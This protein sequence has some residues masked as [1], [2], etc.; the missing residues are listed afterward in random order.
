[1]RGVFTGSSH[2]AAARTMEAGGPAWSGFVDDQLAICAGVII[3]WQGL[4]EAW[5]AFTPVG[6]QH[7]LFCHR[8]VTR[9]LK[10]IIRY[11]RLRRLQADVVLEFSDARRWAESIGFHRESLKPLAGP[12]GET[13]IGYV[14]FPKE[15]P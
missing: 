13:L 12:H 4:G 15:T 10:D 1:M 3:P 9:I 7:P 8:S 14:M 11:H 6:R 2:A 5:A